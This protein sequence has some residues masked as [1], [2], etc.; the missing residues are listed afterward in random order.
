[1][2][3]DGVGA[4][5][6]S[7]AGGGSQSA[8]SGSVNGE[9]PST[10]GGAAADTSANAGASDAGASSVSVNDGIA[11]S[12][13]GAGAGAVLGAYAGARS[14]GT[15]G[16]RGFAGAV[17]T[18]RDAADTGHVW[19]GAALS[20]SHIDDT[21]YLSVAGS[22]FNY[23]TPENE[24]KWTST[25]ANQNQFN[26]AGGDTL[27][28]FAQSH[29]MRV[30][31]HTLVWHS[32]LPTWVSTLSTADAVRQAMTTHI[33]TVAGH[34]KGKLAAWDVVNE[35][36]D[37]ATGNPLRD[38]IFHQKL[39]DT[40][41]DEAFVLAHQADPSALLFYND[42]GIEGMGSK[43]NAA[44]ALVK[45]LR[46]SGVPIDGVG[47]QM[48]IRATG[49]P[50]AADIIANM[51]RIGQLGLLV[52]ISELDVNLCAVTGDQAA[53]FAVQEQR[54]REVV[55][56]CV[57]EPMC[58][59]VTLWGVA[60]KYSWLNNFAPCTKADETGSPWALP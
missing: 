60:D 51:K 43:A 11:G 33:Q 38:S 10:D 35:A 59:A 34:F 23:L 21:S 48:H 50:T 54:Y 41:I 2:A 39:G 15:A 40:Y 27:V 12:H 31:G 18:L 19:I 28:S 13:S 4:S 32:Q 22:E 42:Y 20:A 52:N 29:Q 8:E 37:D 24:M 6:G 58:H 45:R 9:T 25:E 17:A 3:T 5:G 7:D 36:I 30:K 1:M 46:E 44:Y 14:L 53:K 16:I 56:A 26:F 49:S 47:L 55:A 57:A